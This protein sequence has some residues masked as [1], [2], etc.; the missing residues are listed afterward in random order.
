MKSSSAAVKAHS[1]ED[2]ALA[3]PKV[4]LLDVEGTIAPISLVY[5]Q[6]FPY[7]RAHFE[8]YLQQ[9]ASDPGVMNDL[10]LLAHERT[11]ETDQTAPQFAEAGYWDEAIPYLNWL[12]DRDRKSTAL[13][14]LQGRI[15]K[16]GFENDELK[17]TLFEDVPPALERWS[18]NAHVAIYSSGSVAAQLLLLR[19]SSFGDLTPLISGYF[20]TRTGPKTAK[21]SYESI[22]SAMDCGPNE[23]MFFSDAVR[24]LDPARDAGCHTRLVM[25]EG[26]AP[27]ED[28]HGH[29]RIKTF[30]VL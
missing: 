16:V 2:K 17:G 9:H 13:K 11:E 18:T 26:N 7:A 3:T 15:W 21:G 30:K 24:E 27:V 4:F 23:I 5:E 12:M 22:A 6:L 1:I 14:S 10:T 8:Q 25:R 19:H 29:R 20:D 28:A